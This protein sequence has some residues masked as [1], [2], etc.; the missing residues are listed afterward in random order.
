V[1]PTTPVHPL[2]EVWLRPRRVF[3]ELARLPVGVTDYVLAAAQGIG[4]Y[5][6]LYQSKASD[7]HL[8]VSESF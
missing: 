3:R 5:L 2:K 7:A 8:S 4:N 6:M 1:I